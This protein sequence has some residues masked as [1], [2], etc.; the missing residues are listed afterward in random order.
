[1]VYRL[2]VPVHVVRESTRATFVLQ[3]DVRLQYILWGRAVCRGGVKCIRLWRIQGRACP[4]EIVV[5]D[6]RSDRGRKAAQQ[7]RRDKHG[8]LRKS[9]QAG[10]ILQGQQGKA[11]AGRQQD[12]KC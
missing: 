10:E 9:K 11:R 1:M 2:R 8:L 6:L 4:E 3:L 7:Q 5:R 12:L